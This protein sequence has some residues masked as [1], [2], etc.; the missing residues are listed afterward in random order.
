V[1]SVDMYG[2]YTREGMGRRMMREGEGEG[3]EGKVEKG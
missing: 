2:P 1:L 3:E